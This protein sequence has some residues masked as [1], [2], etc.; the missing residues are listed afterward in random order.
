MINEMNNTACPCGKSMLLIK[1]ATTDM[2]FKCGRVNINDNAVI[3]D[4]LEY[5][6]NLPQIYK[7]LTVTN[8]EGNKYVPYFIN[9]KN[10][11]VYLEQNELNDEFE[12]IVA[13]CVDN[14]INMETAE[15]YNFMEFNKVMLSFA[16]NN[17]FI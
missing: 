4:P 9:D 1:N 2:C 6:S 3:L 16:N 14:K 12:Y 5:W 7:D 10:M 13:R 17:K 8:I 11:I 15:R